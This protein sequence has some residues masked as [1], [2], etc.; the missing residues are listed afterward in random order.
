MKNVY[1]IGIDLAKTNF[2]LCGVSREG[3]IVFQKTLK[4]S[5]LLEF[6]GNL[7]KTKVCM[8]ACG[9]SNFWARKFRSM[10]HEVKLVPAQHVKPFVK[11]Q[12]NDRN[13]ALA[14]TEAAARPTMNF[15]SVK[16]A[17]Q[18]D[19]QSVHRVRSRVV[20]NLLE[21]SNQMRGLLAEYGIVIKESIGAFKKE[22]PEI[23]EN[24]NVDLTAEAR[25]LFSSL[26]NEYRDLEKRKVSFDKQI[27]KISKE[28]SVCHRLTQVP[29]VGPMTSTAFVAHI[30]DASFYQNGRQASAALGLVPRQ[31]STGGKQI[32]QGITKRGDVYLRCLLVHGARAF[33]SSIL[34]RP[35]EVL[36]KYELK[37]KN[38]AAK[39]HVNKVI[40]AVANRN[41]RVMLSMMKNGKN[42]EAA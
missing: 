12:K 7:E 25:E 28:N 5:K 41:A 2:E 37:I 24:A 11:S 31:H 36:N 35:D 29:G 34:K 23:L 21:I 19:I 30:G 27:E 39:K 22:V 10:G 3:E 32:L 13:D 15:V 6:F 9:G 4:R 38:M 17:W 40:V 26:Y 8:E 33:V 14:I 42:Y 18:Q 20:K 1:R 16:E